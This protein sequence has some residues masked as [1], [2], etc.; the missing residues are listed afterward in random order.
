MARHAFCQPVC[1]SLRVDRGQHFRVGI[2]AAAKRVDA[3]RYANKEPGKAVP[4]GT[5]TRISS[6]VDLMPL[7]ALDR[8]AVLRESPT[9]RHRP[10]VTTSAELSLHR[11]AP[12]SH[13]ALVGRPVA[14]GAEP[15]V[16]D[17]RH[18]F[19]EHAQQV[20]ATLLVILGSTILVILPARFAPALKALRPRFGALATL[21]LRVVYVTSSEFKRQ[22]GA[23]LTEASTTGWERTW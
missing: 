4:T 2:G 23:A 22:E 19:Q 9:D 21:R 17:P 10:W 16:T 6:G 3:S 11:L 15:G 8:P 12:L 20:Q 5:V 14:S 18:C 1:E 7:G 13:F